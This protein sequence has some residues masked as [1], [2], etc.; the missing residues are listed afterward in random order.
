[1]CFDSLTSFHISFILYQFKSPFRKTPDDFVIMQLHARR[2]NEHDGF[3]WLK[4]S[5]MS[6]GHE[7]CSDG[8]SVPNVE[9]SAWHFSQPEHDV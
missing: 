3:Q 7:V 6:P 1:M 2:E 9:G 4:I 8:L 5:R